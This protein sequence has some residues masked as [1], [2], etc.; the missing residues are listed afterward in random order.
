MNRM[1]GT[2]I[3]VVTLSAGIVLLF[4]RTSDKGSD[5]KER[6]ST[7]ESSQL[8]RPEPEAP[9]SQDSAASVTTPSENL[10]A[11][12]ANV[13]KMA[14]SKATESS[15][16]D[17]INHSEEPFNLTTDQIVYLKDL[18][19]SSDLVDAML[20]HDKQ[21]A[22]TLSSKSIRSEEL[23]SDTSNS[24]P[25]EDSNV[26][27]RTSSHFEPETRTPEYS[28]PEPRQ[29]SVSETSIAPMSQPSA[30]VRN[31][32]V[33]E[34]PTQVTY[35]Y[36][37]L[38]PYGTWV[39]LEGT[40]YVWQPN[41]VVVNA[42]WTPYSDGGHWV[43]T[44]SG[45][46]WASD[47]SWGWAPFHYG[48]WMRT[49]HHR[50]VWCPDTEWAPSWVTWRVHDNYCGWA[51]LPPR[52]RYDH[53]RHGFDYGGTSVSL[54]FD[55]GLD[56]LSFT[57][58]SFDHVA[59]RN[60][61]SHRLPRQT[62]NNIYNQTII[63]NNYGTDS[64]GSLANRGI[65]VDR[66]AAASGRRIESVRLRDQEVRP[67]SNLRHAVFRTHLTK[68]A[69]ETKL[70]EVAVQKV[71]LDQPIV[72][73]LSNAVPESTRKKG[74][75][76]GARFS[77]H[78]RDSSAGIKPAVM[79]PAV[80]QVADKANVA[81]AVLTTDK[82]IGE[83][84]Q[85][86]QEEKKHV[87]RERKHDDNNS[88]TTSSPASSTLAPQ[89]TQGTDPASK[90]TTQPIRNHFEEKKSV[91]ER[92]T[93]VV[94]RPGVKDHKQASG[95]TPVRVEPS[96]SK[97]LP[98]MEKLEEKKSQLKV[99]ESAA[100]PVPEYRKFKKERSQNET[101]PRPAVQLPN[102]QKQTSIRKTDEMPI[103]AVQPRIETRTTNTRSTQS[104][105]YRDF[106]PSNHSPQASSNTPAPQKTA[107]AE[108]RH[109][110]TAPE[111]RPSRRNDSVATASPVAPRV[112][113][114]RPQ[115]PPARKFERA[116]IAVVPPPAPAPV[117][118]A[119]IASPVSPTT[120]PAGNNGN[121]SDHKHHGKDKEKDF[122]RK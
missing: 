31:V 98:V 96:R 121:D 10:S 108:P 8:S 58:T 1:I 66:V 17:F 91:K 71:S 63:V 92:E 114:P 14:D 85:S 19:I 45:W 83:T 27:H 53:R 78:S 4:A 48:R 9:T 94:E 93:A 70:S 95:P 44:D 26:S 42:E 73:E 24:E 56:S 43:W 50:W 36:D 34:V 82:S 100:T 64:S 84:D 61:H 32:V 102:V 74:D 109:S 5:E 104:M 75:H 107:M 29:T 115:D 52:T 68:P 69:V 99:E 122:A 118:A 16:I 88:L 35:F 113:R 105:E 87:R 106:R 76:L 89:I 3:T 79:I 47:Y 101:S 46:Y 33:R 12:A 120:P 116:A 67:N 13:I 117:K 40:G 49:S 112:E 54:N 65:S 37:S 11:P 103:P 90:P 60:W 77:S 23:P 97:D 81:P 22:T 25:V 55:F 51:P 80:P 110:F 7:A 20:N 6:F 41:A 28:A 18:G 15:L 72:P 111:S 86:R 21:L 39:Y 30:P 38:S 59:D 57:F 119:V 2:L 62:V